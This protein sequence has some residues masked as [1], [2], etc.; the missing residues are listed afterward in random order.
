MVTWTM[1]GGSAYIAKDFWILISAKAVR[2]LKNALAGLKSLAERRSS[3]PVQGGLRESGRAI[4]SKGRLYPEY[5]A[6]CGLSGGRGRGRQRARGFG[7]RVRLQSAG[8]PLRAR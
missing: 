8:A 6:P 3:R 5:S 1:S 7:Q 2:G 4:D